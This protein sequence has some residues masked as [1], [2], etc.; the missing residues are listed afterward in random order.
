MALKVKSEKIRTN[1]KIGVFFLLFF[2]WL[3][4]FAALLVIVLFALGK[5]NMINLIYFYNIFSPGTV[6][7]PLIITLTTVLAFKRSMIRI[8]PAS[9]VNVDKLQEHFYKMGYRVIEE[10]TNFIKYQRASWFSRFIWLNLDKPIIQINEDE[11]VITLKKD[12]EI[13]ITP[14]L[15][16]GKHFEITSDNK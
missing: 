13:S 15:T 6:V 9:N 7:L 14:L 4:I 1:G 10:K 12:I 8:S 16:Y 5:L 2:L 11:V 3:L